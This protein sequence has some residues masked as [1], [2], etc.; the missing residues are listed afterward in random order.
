MT[1][2]TKKPAFWTKAMAGAV[3]A[4]ALIAISP[5]PAAAQ[6]NNAAGAKPAAPSA[7][8]PPGNWIKVCEKEAAS[9]KE[10]CVVTQEIHGQD[11]SFLASAGVRLYPD[12]GEKFAVIFGFPL[13]MLLQ[14]GI[15]YQ[16]DQGEQKSGQFGICLPTGCFAEIPADKA[17]VEQFKKGTD[18]V[19]LAISGRGQTVPFRLS[20]I[21][22]TKTFDGPPIDPKVLAEN[23]KKLQA[24]IQRRAEERRKKLQEQQ[25]SGGAAPAAG[26]Q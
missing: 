12:D 2:M 19:L 24:E 3:A 22:F 14:P 21:G 4:A 15:R 16:I 5:V 11:G 1:S 10:V 25:G 6:D 8:P 13:G 20:L 26:S 23:Q 17:T 18:L 7:P 9:G